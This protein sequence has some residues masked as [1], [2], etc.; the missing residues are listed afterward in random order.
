MS[1]MKK[2]TVSQTMLESLTM[3]EWRILY[4][5]IMHRGKASINMTGEAGMCLGHLMNHANELI[6]KDLIV[7]GET[8]KDYVI[9]PKGRRMVKKMGLAIQ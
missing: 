1:F 6:K 5:L 4:L 9:T 3:Q 8:F 2:K 7:R